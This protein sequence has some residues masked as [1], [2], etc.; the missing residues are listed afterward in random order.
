MII[1]LLRGCFIVCGTFYTIQA[2]IY[3]FDGQILA[4][5]VGVLLGLLCICLE[6]F[7]RLQCF[8]ANKTGNHD[9]S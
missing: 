4:T 6:G 2:V 9:Q 8:E 1:A 7:I 3:A 5:F